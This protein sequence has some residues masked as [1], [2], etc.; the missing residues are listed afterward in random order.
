MKVHEF[1][2]VVHE[3]PLNLRKYMKSTWKYTKVHKSTRKY[4]KVH[5]SAELV[6]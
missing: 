2:D 3:I 5:E 1:A 6:Q 4:I